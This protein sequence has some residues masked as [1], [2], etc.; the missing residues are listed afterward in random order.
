MTPDGDTGDTDTAATSTDSAGGSG[1]AGGPGTGATE[2]GGAAAPGPPSSLDRPF[3]SGLPGVRRLTLVRHGQQQ[4][5]SAGGHYVPT[6]WVDPPL[7]DLGHRQAETTAATLAGEPVDAVVCSH[8]R[9]A[10]DTARAVGARHG[11]EPVVYPELREVETYRGLPEGLTLPEAVPPVVW[12]GITARFT[13]TPRWDLLP[14]SE[15]S[16]AFRSRVVT[17]VE[18]V[19]ALHDVAHLVV[20]CHGGVINAYL[21]ELLGIADDMF[22]RPAHASL[23]RLL[24]HEDRRVLHTLNELTHL[25]AADP[26]LVTV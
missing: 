12:Q 23:T 16:A 7:S 17:A 2:S 4:A 5:P 15:P 14:F 9:R 8:L 1:R 18:G 6:D 20:V 3:L 24:V 19:L 11:L 21:A 13:R 10:H 26:S 22:F 25:A